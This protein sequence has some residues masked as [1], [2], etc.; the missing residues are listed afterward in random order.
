MKKSLIIIILLLFGI[1]ISASFVDAD[2]ALEYRMIGGLITIA[3]VLITW[4]IMWVQLFKSEPK[5]KKVNMSDRYKDTL[6]KELYKYGLESRKLKK[7]LFN[8]FKDIQIAVSN[9]EQDILSDNLTKDLYDF[10]IDEIE[11]LNSKNQKNII[12]DIELKN[13]KIYDVKSEYNILTVNVYLNVK[14]YD[15]IVDNNTL[16]CLFGDSV[17]KTEFEFELTFINTSKDNDDD[18]NF[19]MSKKICINEMKVEK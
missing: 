16:N 14:M 4:G 15:Y 7:L 8:K 19:V 9:Y 12:K 18:M 1:V 17:F 13:I 2:T 5:V 3:V 10:Y 6:E 11:K